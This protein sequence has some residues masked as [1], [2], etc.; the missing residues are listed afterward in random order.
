MTRRDEHGQ[1]WAPNTP[2]PVPTAY[3]GPEVPP[4]MPIN[5]PESLTVDQ[6]VAILDE[7]WGGFGVGWRF[8]RDKHNNHVVAM[9][10]LGDHK[11]DHATIHPSLTEA[12]RKACE[13]EAT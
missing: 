11:W 12:L 10:A 2:L 1:R 7:R 4:P 3:A 6:M 13:V 9:L 5:T 8:D